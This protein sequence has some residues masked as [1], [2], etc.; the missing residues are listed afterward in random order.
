MTWSAQVRV[1]SQGLSSHFES[2]VCKYFDGF[3]FYKF[4]LTRFWLE[5]IILFWTSSQFLVM[6][7]DRRL[8]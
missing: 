3:G 8:L 1:E 6:F 4:C 5:L 2:L 7:W